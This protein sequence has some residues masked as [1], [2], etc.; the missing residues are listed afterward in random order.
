[1]QQNALRPDD[2]ESIEVDLRLFPLIHVNPSTGLEGKFS[3]A[4]NVAL[5]VV[6]GWPEIMDYT[7]ARTQEPPVP[8]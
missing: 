8:I 1:M 3:M 6:K 5:A 7:A 2:I 4:F